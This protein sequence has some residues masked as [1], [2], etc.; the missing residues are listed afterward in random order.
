MCGRYGRRGDK[1]RIAEWMPESCDF[2]IDQGKDTVCAHGLSL[3][4]VV[5]KKWAKRLRQRGREEPL[6][7]IMHTTGTLQFVEAQAWC[8]F[9]GLVWLSVRQS[10]SR[11]K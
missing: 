1:Q 2:L 6:L 9:L 10:D 7:E 11:P 5:I 8:G 3:Y 4:S